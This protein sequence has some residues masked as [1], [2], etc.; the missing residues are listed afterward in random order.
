MM[1]T[2]CFFFLCSLFYANSSSKATF[3]VSSIQPRSLRRMADV[4]D[5][6]KSVTDG[7]SE[8]HTYE[9]YLDSQIGEKDLNYLQ[10][11]QSA[12]LR[13]RSWQRT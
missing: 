7:F 5:S 3:S 4:D 9:D 12:T 11:S 6:A 8:F 13:P 1:C 10:V 2:I